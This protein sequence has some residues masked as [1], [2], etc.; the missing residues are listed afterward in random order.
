MII[1]VLGR[2]SF[3]NQTS[4]VLSSKEN[5]LEMSLIVFE[6]GRWHGHFHTVNNAKLR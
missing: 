1:D 5:Y 6:S 4:R 3:T 2:L